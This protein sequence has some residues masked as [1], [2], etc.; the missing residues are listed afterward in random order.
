MEKERA[1]IPYSTLIGIIYFIMQIIIFCITTIWRLS[2]SIKI[3]ERSIG[4][5]CQWKNELSWPWKSVSY[6]KWSLLVDSDG[7]W[8][9]INMLRSMHFMHW[10]AINNRVRETHI[11][12]S[13]YFVRLGFLLLISEGAFSLEYSNLIYHKTSIGW[14]FI[15]G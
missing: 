15:R 8:R 7:T 1:T 14:F 9:W 6:V 2:I 10:G 5:V 4:A 12:L 13:Y 11:R 3:N